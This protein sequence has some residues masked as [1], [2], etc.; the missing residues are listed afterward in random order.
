MSISADH[1]IINDCIFLLI[2][3][4]ALVRNRDHRLVIGAEDFFPVLP[5]GQTCTAADSRN[6]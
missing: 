3:N 6:T 2:F 5:Q 1:G 4:P